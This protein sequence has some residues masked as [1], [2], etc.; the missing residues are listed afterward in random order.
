[1]TLSKYLFQD[2][3]KCCGHQIKS[4]VFF[5]NSPEDG[6]GLRH[7]QSPQPPAVHVHD[8]V[9]D[10]KPP[11][12]ATAESMLFEAGKHLHWT[13]FFSRLS[14]S[15]TEVW[16]PPPTTADRSTLASSR[17]AVAPFRIDKV[18]VTFEAAGQSHVSRKRNFRGRRRRRRSFSSRDATP[19]RR[20][21][22]RRRPFNSEF[23]G[24]GAAAGNDTRTT[25]PHT[26][27]SSPGEEEEE[28]EGADG[29]TR[30]AELNF[31]HGPVARVAFIRLCGTRLQLHHE[32]RRQETPKSWQRTAKPF[33][34][35]P[36][37]WFRRR[38]RS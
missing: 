4:W 35:P 24:V 28:R 36:P 11:V 3:R 32:S 12:S 5:S 19:R 25:H 10:E 31:N 34:P 14:A 20:P 16:S 38:R 18:R 2:S 30:S 7:G 1:M 29:G 17:V 37:S 22:R 26:P 9:P 13:N 15:L 33:L 23:G 6:F 8:L 27:H 21:R